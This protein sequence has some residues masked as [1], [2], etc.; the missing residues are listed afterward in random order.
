M[1]VKIWGYAVFA[2][3][4]AYPEGFLTAVHT[5]GEF[6]GSIR[7]MDAYKAAK[8]DSEDLKRR[9]E[10]KCKVKLI[11]IDAAIDKPTRRK[12]NGKC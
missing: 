3:T 12:S 1:R 4:E 7:A 10:A 8:K 11:E 5:Y 6:G 9:L 2:K